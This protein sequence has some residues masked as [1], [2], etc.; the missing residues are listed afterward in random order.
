MEEIADFF[1]CSH[2]TISTRFQQEFKL[3]KASVRKNL[4]MWQMRRAQKG[5]DKM[6]IHL[7]QQFLGQAQKIETRNT[8]AEDTRAIR[9]KFNDADTEP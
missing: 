1:D 9:D 5:S 6:L 8:E 3:G 4:R 7:G 2:A